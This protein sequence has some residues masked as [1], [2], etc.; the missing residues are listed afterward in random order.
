MK[1]RM[2]TTF[3]H[4][5]GLT[6]KAEAMLWGRGVIVWPDLRER[7]GEHVSGRTAGRA[8]AALDRSERALRTDDARF[9]AR[10][11][12]P[13]E[14]A[15]LLP[16]VAAR[17][18]YLDIET[19]GLDRSAE[20]TT[21]ATYDG[22]RLRLY[23]RDRNLEALPAELSANAVLV[24]FNG[25]RFDI[26]FLR[27]RFG[28]DFGRAW[29]HLDMCTL[30][31]RRGITGGL[32]A[33]ERRMGL[34]RR[35]LPALTGADAVDLWEKWQRGERQ[36]LEELLTYNAEDVLVLERLLRVAYNSSTAMCPG[37]RPLEPVRQPPSRKASEEYISAL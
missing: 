36:A 13:G 20:T 30:L 24:T 34:Q 3:C 26:P 11:L 22:Q 27:R 33:C 12:P 8:I 4:L 25:R 6:T 2:R 31:K 19:T 35:E 29:L 28:Q 16:M 17:I 23:V 5:P 37:L 10:C 9:F 14:G 32:K 15:R 1:N 18:V 7:C 21:V